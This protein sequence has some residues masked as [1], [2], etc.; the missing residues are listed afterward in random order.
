MKF[1]ATVLLLCVTDVTSAPPDDNDISWVH[2]PTQNTL[3]TTSTKTKPTTPKIFTYTE[4]CAD[5]ASEWGAYDKMELGKE[6]NKQHVASDH[7]CYNQIQ[8]TLGH[9]MACSLWRM[10]KLA[11]A[12][13]YGTGVNTTDN[14]ITFIAVKNS[15]NK[16]HGLR[17]KWPARLAPTLCYGIKRMIH[18]PDQVMDNDYTMNTERDMISSVSIPMEMLTANLLDQVFEFPKCSDQTLTADY[19]SRSI[20]HYAKS[21]KSFLQTAAVEKQDIVADIPH[22]RVIDTSSWRQPVSMNTGETIQS[23]MA[24]IGADL[25]KANEG[26]KHFHLNST[27]QALLAHLL[28]AKNWQKEHGI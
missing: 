7:P 12:E 5:A 11:V 9:A 15:L 21:A 20:D 17:K 18:C 10:T 28:D 24:D 16:N 8:L 22:D 3:V 6:E 1:G 25:K 4:T 23:L 2:N 27:R 13:S 14:D 26:G 19:L